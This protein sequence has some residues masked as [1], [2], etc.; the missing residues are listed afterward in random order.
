VTHDQEE[1]F[2][3]SDRVAI[4]NAGRIMQFD[5]PESALPRGPANAFVARFVGFENLIPIEG[6]RPRRRGRDG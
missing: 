2:S 4:M 5:T 3:I 1:A 6:R